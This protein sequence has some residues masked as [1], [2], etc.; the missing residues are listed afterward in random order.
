MAQAMRHKGSFNG[1]TPAAPGKNCTKPILFLT[2]RPIS[3]HKS[4]VIQKGARQ[5]RTISGPVLAP[6]SCNPTSKS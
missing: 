1:H 3:V 2:D 6:C 4:L 5:R